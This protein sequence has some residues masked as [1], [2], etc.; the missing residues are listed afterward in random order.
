MAVRTKRLAIGDSAPANAEKTIYTAPAGE[1]VIVKDVRTAQVS[2]A[3]TRVV[4][5]VQSGTDRGSLIDEAAPGPTARLVGGFVVL[6]PGDQLRVFSQGGVFSAW[7][8][9]AELEG[10]AD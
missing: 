1:T 3:P 4:V 10:L 9:G 2:G 8:S 5:F 7:V 6:M